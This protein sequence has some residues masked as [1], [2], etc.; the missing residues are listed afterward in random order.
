MVFLIEKS[1]F[2]RKKVFFNKKVFF[3]RKQVFLVVVGPVDN[4]PN[5]VT[6]T[7]VR[8]LRPSHVIHLH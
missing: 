5:G 2:N 8:P 6:P 7:E 1:I 4:W 3:F